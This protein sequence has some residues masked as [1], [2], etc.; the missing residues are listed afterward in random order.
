MASLKPPF[1]ATDMD[2]LY[3]KVSAGS[4]KKLPSHY[5]VDLNNLVKSM[6]KVKP[7]Q[8]PSADRLLSSSIIVNRLE[9]GHL[10][11]AADTEANEMLKTI[12]LP[13]NLHYLT[14]KL[15]E[16]NYEPIVTVSLEMSNFNHKN[17][18]PDLGQRTREENSY[19]DGSRVADSVK[20][21]KH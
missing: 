17:T 11:E 1:R 6:L 19:L 9:K 7:G 14:S 15:P 5:S 12:R 4:F 16:A 10:V 21:S 13:N 20:K 3:K 2:G 18:M 8:R